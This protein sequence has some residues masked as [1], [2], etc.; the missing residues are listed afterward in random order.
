MLRGP[1]LFV[2][3]VKTRTQ[4]HGLWRKAAED[5]GSLAEAR[6][7]AALALKALEVREALV[8]E[9]V[10]MTQVSNAVEGHGNPL[11]GS[12]EKSFEDWVPW[13]LGLL[14]V[15]WRSPTVSRFESVEAPGQFP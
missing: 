10:P 14:A 4:V 15:A 9:R 11:G 12:R 13:M 7:L 6:G 5:S 2:M 8:G 3:L 1:W